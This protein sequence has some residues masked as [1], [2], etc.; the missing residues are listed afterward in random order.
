M[1]RPPWTFFRWAMAAWAVGASWVM[2]FQGRHIG[3][4]HSEQLRHH[5]ADLFPEGCP[6]L[7]HRPDPFA[8]PFMLPLHG[9]QHLEPCL[10]LVQGPPV[11]FQ[12]P[13]LFPVGP[14]ALFQGPVQL[15]GGFFQLLFPVFQGFQAVLFPL[16]GGGHFLESLFRLPDLFLQAFLLP[17]DP[18]LFL[19]D[20]C[21]FVPG[22]HQGPHAVKGLFLP[23][24]QFF[25]PLPDGFRQGLLFSGGAFQELLGPVL[26][27]FQPVVFLRHQV[28]VLLVP[29]QF[30]FQ[31][32]PVFGQLVHPV[33]ALLDPF[34]LDRLLAPVPG[35]FLFPGQD[36]FLVGAV[37]VF[38]FLEPLFQGFLLFTQGPGQFRQFLQLGFQQGEFF[39]EPGL[40]FFQR[41]QL[42]QQ[43]GHLHLPEPGADGFILPGFFRCC[44]QGHQLVFDLALDIVDPQQVGRRVVQFPEGFLLP[45]PVLGDPRRFLENG[46]PVFRT[47]VEDLVD[48][49]LTDDGQGPPSQPG[50][51]QKGHHVLQPAVLPVDGIFA[52]PA[53]EHPALEAHLVEIHRQ[54]V[55]RVVEH[56]VHFRHAH[57]TAAAAAGED[58]VLHFGAPEVLYALFPHDPPDG[59]GDIAFAAAVG[60]HNGGDPRLEFDIYF[61]C[62]GFEPMG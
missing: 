57:G 29:G 23:G 35:G 21:Q 52:V 25:F 47:A 39:R 32:R 27:F 42:A 59:V 28:Q 55:V 41:S 31:G 4:L 53:P 12:G 3:I 20:P 22:H 26:G 1:A 11:L 58:H 36:L 56:Q 15:P 19:A 24:L 5:T 6:G 45:D 38:P 51:R 16:E 62:K 17:V 61:V 18:V 50:I 44:F 7:Q 40:F 54:G 46:P 13:F 33:P 60:A 8:E 48:L 34:L 49:V 30:L 10:L 9:G 14:D 2:M 37:G 43:P